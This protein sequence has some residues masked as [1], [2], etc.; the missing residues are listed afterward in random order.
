MDGK[1]LNRLLGDVVAIVPR[2]LNFTR[3]EGLVNFGVSNNA[4][5]LNI[6]AILEDNSDVVRL[7]NLLAQNVITQDLWH[8]LA[9]E[10]IQ[11]RSN[12][13][14]NHPDQMRFSIDVLNSKFNVD[15]KYDVFHDDYSDFTENV[16]FDY[17]LRGYVPD[18]DFIKSE[19]NKALAFHDEPL[20]N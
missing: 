3:I 10:F 4:A 8:N 5:S 11:F 16:Y 15:F 9:M 7:L 12:N 6:Y 1:Q 2:D 14:E 17:L 18:S 20:L 13:F 19:V